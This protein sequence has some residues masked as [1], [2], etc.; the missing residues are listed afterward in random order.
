MTDR[1]QIVL[2]NCAF[3]ARHGVLGEEEVLG[4]RFFVDV[5]MEVEAPEALEDDA[6]AKTVDY[7]DAFKLVEATVTGAR[8]YLIEALANDICKALLARYAP[9]CRVAITVRKPSAPIAGILD[10]AEVTVTRVR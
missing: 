3:F 6:V 9:I 10:H 7:G 5:E 8:R 2:R 4:Q 1:Y